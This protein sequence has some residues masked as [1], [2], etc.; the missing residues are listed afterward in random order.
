MVIKKEILYPMFL[1]CIKYTD[2]IF[3]E[4]V[5]EELSYG[6]TPYGTYISK[7]FFCCNY[8]DK[9]FNYKID[10]KNPEELHNDIYSLL[11]K[12]LGLLSQKD[13]IKKRLEFLN[14]D[15]ENKDSKKTWSSIRKK[16][17]KDLLIENYVISMK[18]KYFLTFKQA[19]YLIS[20]IYIG[21]IFKI[22]TVKDIDYNDG[23][24]NNINGIE[25]KKK[26]IIL[27]KDMYDIKMPQS[28]I[29]I[30]DKNLMSSNWDKYIDNL[31][32]M[33]IVD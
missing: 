1:E 28:C 16:N 20:I 27:L 14:T 7:N 21:M 19:K 13:K 5:F 25:F 32:K 3:W 22:I 18:N 8:K 11:V 4:N 23:K 17:I 9:G 31:K 10:D 30:E 29:L 2:D 6:K 15:E 26:D 12:K 33:V 24:I